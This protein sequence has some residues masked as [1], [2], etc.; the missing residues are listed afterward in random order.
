MYGMAYMVYGTWYGGFRVDMLIWRV[1]KP[2]NS[3]N[4]RMSCGKSSVKGSIWGF[5][6]A[7]IVGLRRFVKEVF[8]QDSY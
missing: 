7:A 1:P 5:C 2:P 6:N 4:D 8:E 3:G